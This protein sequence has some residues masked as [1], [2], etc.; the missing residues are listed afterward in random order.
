MPCWQISSLRRRSRCSARP[1]SPIRSGRAGALQDNPV[2]SPDALL[3]Q[4]LHQPRLA[5]KAF[6]AFLSAV[7]QRQALR[8]R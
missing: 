1:S 3:E 6:D 5:L 4:E 2:A 7:E 8:H